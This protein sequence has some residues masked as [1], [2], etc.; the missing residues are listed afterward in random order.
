MATAN[1]KRKPLRGPYSSPASGYPVP[2]PLLAALSS[3]LA[4]CTLQITDPLVPRTSPL[5][6]P[7]LRSMN[8]I[9]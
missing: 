9:T 8:W 2:R 3:A 7:L 4:L 5:N 1:L 6:L